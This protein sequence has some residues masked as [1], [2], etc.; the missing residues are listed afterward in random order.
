MASIGQAVAGPRFYETDEA[1]FTPTC[2]QIRGLFK[3][4]LFGSGST[5]QKYTSTALRRN[6]A[7]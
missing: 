1:R 4:V 2:S 7:V 6:F 3:I 5:G